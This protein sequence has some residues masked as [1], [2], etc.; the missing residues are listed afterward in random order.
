M[1]LGANLVLVLKEYYLLKCLKVNVVKIGG[2]SHFNA[3][4][5]PWHFSTQSPYLHVWI[6]CYVANRPLKV[7]RSRSI[8]EIITNTT[9]IKDSNLDE[10]M[11]ATNVIA[12]PIMIN[13]SNF[14]LIRKC[15]RYD[16]KKL[17]CPN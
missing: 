16:N 9:T 15:L 5:P 14:M 8:H 13:A 3:V 2:H 6:S 12:S 11:E 10:P 7:P 4:F 17:K 1:G